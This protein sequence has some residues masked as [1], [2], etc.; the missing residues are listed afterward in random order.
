MA[1]RHPALIRLSHDHHH[2]LA[3]ALR[4]RKHA[5][6]QMNPGNPQALKGQAVEVKT[7][8][9]TN[10]RLHF[11]AEEKVLFPLI[12]AASPD[13]EALVAKL[14][15]E[16]ERLRQEATALDNEARLSKTLFNLG[17]LLESHVRCEERELFPLFERTVSA[18]LTE[19]ARQGIEEVLRPT[20]RAND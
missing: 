12:I 1:K 20:P 6:G 13:A 19:Q 3:M 10:L 5:L 7:F 9:D 2:A 14:I 11:E 18:E 15:G 17:D 4:C 8:F 16:H